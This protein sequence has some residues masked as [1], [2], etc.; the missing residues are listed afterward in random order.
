MALYGRDANGNDAYIKASGTGAVES[1]FVTYH[2]AFS[3]DIKFAS[4]TLTASGDVIAAVAGTK[5]RVLSMC[6]SS[7]AA[8]SVKFQTDASSDLTGEFYLPANGIST[9]SNP[10]G[11][12]ETAAGDKLNLVLTGTA[13][14]GVTVSYREV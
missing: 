14:V 13:S 10:L 3:D 9:F 4:A 11:L 6:L 2:D 5:L 12:F 1:G 8:C 7:D